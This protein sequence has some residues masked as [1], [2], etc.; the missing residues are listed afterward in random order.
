MKK[1]ILLCAAGM[2]TG[3]LV[4]KMRE[5][6]QELECAYE[7]KA[8]PIAEADNVCMDADL[9]LLGPQ[10]RFQTENVK[11]KVSCPVAAIDMTAYGTMNGK[12]V[13]QQVKKIM[14]D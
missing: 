11:T 10:V 3:M 8:F 5:A 13:I 1:I 4:K 6:A 12:K 9:V 14:G 2:S 7:I